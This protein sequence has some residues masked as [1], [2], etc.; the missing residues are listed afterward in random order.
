MRDDAP[1]LDHIV[2]L[3]CGGA[4]TYQNTQ[5]TCRECNGRKGATILGQLRL[6]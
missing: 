3:A 6:L 5:C 2:P 4:H 1:E